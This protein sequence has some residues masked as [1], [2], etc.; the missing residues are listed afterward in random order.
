M[1]GQQFN[2]FLEAIEANEGLQEKLQ[3]AADVDAVVAIAKDAGFTIS[4]DDLKRVQAE[5]SEDVLDETLEQAN[6]GAWGA[7]GPV[8]SVGS[9]L[10]KN[11]PTNFVYTGANQVAQ[12][13]R[14]VAKWK[15]GASAAAVGTGIGFGV[16][17]LVDQQKSSEMEDLKELLDKAEE[18]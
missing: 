13:G 6:G 15:A 3:A 12:G 14:K 5:V 18:S 7:F 8:L 16:D 4:A 1:S 9:R 11:V 10:P 17:A 2:A